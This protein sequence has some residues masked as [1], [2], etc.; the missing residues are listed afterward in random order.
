MGIYASNERDGLTLEWSGYSSDEATIVDANRGISTK[1]PGNTLSTY[2]SPFYIGNGNAV[3]Y[4]GSYI[5]IG[6]RTSTEY[7]FRLVTPG[8]GFYAS[9][10]LAKNI[11]PYYQG[12]EKAVLSDLN[13]DGKI[14]G[15]SNFY[16]T[17]TTIHTT[18]TI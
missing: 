12:F 14:E 6:N 16:I 1:I 13:G 15:F 5:V 8:E 10:G 4:A 7:G 3:A 2:S 17:N 11:R 9:G 18:V